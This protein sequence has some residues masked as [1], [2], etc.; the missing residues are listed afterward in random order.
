M[1]WKKGEATIEAMLAA[2]ELLRGSATDEHTAFLLKT[3]MGYLRTAHRAFDDDD[4]E[5][6][7]ANAWESARLAMSYVLARQGLRAAGRDTHVVVLNA[8]RAQ[9]LDKTALE[10]PTRNLRQRRHDLNYPEAGVVPASLQETQI[11]LD[12]VDSLLNKVVELSP[13]FDI[14]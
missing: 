6:S 14:F 13:H 8:A 4:L 7:I 10:D 12:A 5:Q 2:G 9:Y 3:A 1:R 11:Y